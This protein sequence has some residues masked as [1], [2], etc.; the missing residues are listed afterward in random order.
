MNTLFVT[1]RAIHYA[2]AIVLF[3]ELVFAIAVASSVAYAARVDAIDSAR[4]FRVM[5]WAISRRARVGRAWFVLEAAVMSGT[6]LPIGDRSR[7]A[8][9]VLHRTSFG[10]VWDSARGTLVALCVIGIAIQRS[11]SVRSNDWRCARS[12]RSVAA[13]YLGAL[14]WAGHAACRV[15][16]RGSRPEDRRRRTSPAAGA[17]LGSL[18]ALVDCARR[19][20]V[21]RRRC[22]A[23]PAL[24]DART[25]ERHALIASGLV[26]ACI[27]SAPCR[28]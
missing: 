11:R 3:G 4:I 26:N 9:V 8:R 28:H 12:L 17:W 6:P 19:A 16:G 21:R 25:R 23:L 27:K 5:A 14:A 7:H 10:R 20:S 24:L 22:P 18:P 13:A 15:R 2:S 1:A